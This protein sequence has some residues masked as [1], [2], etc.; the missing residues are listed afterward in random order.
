MSVG[1]FGTGKVADYT[2]AIREVPQ[3]KNKVTNLGLFESEGLTTSTA[4]IDIDGYEIG[5]LGTHSR[6]SPAKRMKHE[7]AKQLPIII[8][9]IELEDYIYPEDVE[10][11]RMPGSQEEDKLTRVRAKRLAQLSG[12]IDLTHEYMRLSAVKGKT[13][14]GAGKVLFD[15]YAQLGESQKTVDFDMSGTTGLK[16]TL[17]DIKRHIEDSNKS[18]G[19]I[20][21]I[22]CLCS[23]SFFN[24]LVNNAEIAEVYSNQAGITNPLKDDLR[25]GFVYEGI[26]FIEY[27]GSVVLEN[28]NTEAMIEDKTAYFLPRGI[29]GMFREYYAPKTDM[30]YVN[31]EGVSKY[32]SEFSHPEGKWLKLSAETNPL[33]INTRPQMVVKMTNSAA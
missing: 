23:S 5:V 21:E 28:G 10:G 7:N 11:K 17:L 13:K 8:P 30:N 15:A 20:N 29:Q 19:M 14:D 16:S 31:T 2:Q 4:I 6:R 3:V 9:H 1:P 24:A 26:Y 32:A 12:N 33:M 18:G 27:G 22:I 25:A